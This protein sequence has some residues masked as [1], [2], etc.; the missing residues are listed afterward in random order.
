[1]NMV[2]LDAVN[3]FKKEFDDI[4]RNVHNKKLKNS[5]AFKTA[6]GKKWARKYDYDT[7]IYANYVYWKINFVS[8]SKCFIVPKKDSDYEYLIRRNDG[9][10]YRGDTMNSWSTT[11]NDFMRRYGGDYITDYNGKYIPEGYSSWESYLSKPEHY[12]SDLP[13]YINN[14]MEYVYTIGNFIPVPLKP[15][16]NNKHNSIYQNYW[17]LTLLD[18]FRFYKGDMQ[19]IPKLYQDRKSGIQNW[20]ERFKNTDG[21]A[22]WNKFVEGNYMQPFVEKIGKNEYGEPYELWD[23]HFVKRGLPKEEWQFE[24]FFVNA[25]IRILERGRLIAKKLVDNEMKAT[26]SKQ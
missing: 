18:I 25:R 14:F 19:S 11:L 21:T 8:N 22:D 5:P 7:S 17:D 9:I 23:G 15:D 2:Y 12:K 3:E 1:M 10:I 24:Q 6:F 4:Y 16:F 20:L 26:K 13:G